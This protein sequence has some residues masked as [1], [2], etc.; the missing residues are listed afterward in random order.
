MT[1]HILV[2]LSVLFVG[3]ASKSNTSSETDSGGGADC[4]EDGAVVFA[5]NCAGCHGTDGT[6]KPD[7]DLTTAVPLLSDGVLADVIANGVDSMPAPSLSRCEEDAVFLFVRDTF[8][9]H[10]GG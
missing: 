3:C 8:G 10:G 5:N 2:C 9:Q 7:A 6:S 4:D 1:P